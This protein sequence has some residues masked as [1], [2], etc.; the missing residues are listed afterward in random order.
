MAEFHLI[1]CFGQ[2]EVLE[3]EAIRA[4]WLYDNAHVEVPGRV[5]E[6]L[7]PGSGGGA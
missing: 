3:V 1:G 5:R 4:G 2:S 6:G 7:H